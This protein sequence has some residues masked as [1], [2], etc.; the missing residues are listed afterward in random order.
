[1]LMAS[2]ELEFQHVI[3]E[4]ASDSL[5]A[6]I[7]S[8][9]AASA[10]CEPTD[11]LMQAVRPKRIVDE[12][13]ASQDDAGSVTG[14]ST[15]FLVIDLAMIFCSNATLLRLEAADFQHLL[16]KE[17][18]RYRTFESATIE[19]LSYTAHGS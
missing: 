5:Q 7:H 11:L 4:T 17:M 2:P 16:R 10:R 15:S 14:P 9:V 13:T 19:I 12:V 6:L 1:M 3:S 18:T 8:S